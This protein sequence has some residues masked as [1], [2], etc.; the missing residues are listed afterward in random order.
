MED[1]IVSME[2]LFAPRSIL[3]I[4][5]SNSLGKW[6]GL[7]FRNLLDGGYKGEI[8][9]VNPREESVQGRKAYSS[10]AD[11]PGPVDM[12]V[13]AIPAAAIPDAISE[14]AELGVKAGVVVTAGFAELGDHGQ[15]LQEEMVRR[16]REA[17]MILV[18]PNGQG[19]SV[20]SRDL[21]PWFPRFRPK[22]GCIG[23]A[24]QSGNLS[25][26]LSAQL[27]EFGLGCSKVIS[28][29]NCADL[30]WCDYLEYFR[31]DPETKVILLHV[32]GTGDGR[33]F[34]HFARGTAM[35]KPIVLLKTGR[36]N[37]GIRAARSHTGVLAGSDELFDHVCR[38]A[39]LVRADAT[40][41][42][43]LAAAALLT[44]PLPAGRRVG[45]ITG[46]GGL[47]VMAADAC[48]RLGLDVVQFS[49]PL[50]ERLRPHLPP[51]WSPNNPVD[52]VGGLGYAGPADL[53]PILM[54][55]DEVDGVIVIGVGWIYPIIDGVDG[56]LDL[57]DPKNAALKRRVE[58][59]VRD[60]GLFAAHARRW[61]KPLILTSPVA[62]SVLRR[63]YD[64]LLD[65]LRQGVMLYPTVEDAA[66]AFSVL[67]DRHDFLRKM[68]A[69]GIHP[70]S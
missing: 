34:L 69:Q 14:C 11:V 33:G 44:T 49:G 19:I 16:A 54:E 9:P 40:D 8:Y 63:K 20:P 22:P 30:T 39:G 68:K 37:A 32:E 43:V 67:A 29:G 47:G 52:L 42:A 15:A 56:P 70:G 26:I 50:I 12:A 23:I 35:E 28:A 7:V 21:H 58:E 41:D 17:G 45:I 59:T 66:K 2:R 6:G 57:T 27:A 65:L 46:G 25:T 13:F 18:G 64:G 62:R 60:C 55:S 24:S 36:T 61:N 48:A 31:R 3:F 53:V 4:G 51:W 10:V 38:Q 1:R 5:A